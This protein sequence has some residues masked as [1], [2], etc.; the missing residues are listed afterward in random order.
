MWYTKEEIMRKYP[1]GI[2]TYKKKI[3]KLKDLKYSNY[4]RLIKKELNNSNLKYIIVREIHSSIIDE[5]FGD[6]RLPSKSNID[7]VIKW[8]NCNKWDWFCNIIPSNAFPN[9]LIVKI[10]FFFKKLKEICSTGVKL[11][12]TIEKNTKDNFYHCHFLIKTEDDRIDKKLIESL[13]SDVCEPNTKRENRI[14]VE[15]YNFEKF[16]SK[17]SDYSVKNMNIGFDLLSFRP[18]FN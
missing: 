4:T 15:Q 13:L 17:G 7:K 2:T 9:E 1:M 6:V 3:K 16:N 8:V 11:F 5:V 10:E 12:Y 18:K 14:Y